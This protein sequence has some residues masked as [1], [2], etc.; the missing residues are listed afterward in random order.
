MA[1]TDAAQF[2]IPRHIIQPG[3]VNAESITAN[4]TLTY[5]DSTYQ[6]ITTNGALDLTLP[7]EK[8][9]AVFVV[10]NHPDSAGVLTVK[11]SDGSVI[12]T[13]AAGEAFILVCDGTNWHVGLK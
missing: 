6:I 4:R 2:K 1:F 12:D 9:G 8:D 5:A 11:D 7:V 3:G 10:R 13:R